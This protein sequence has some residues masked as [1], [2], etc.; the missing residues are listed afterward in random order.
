ML[1]KGIYVTRLL[2]QGRAQRHHN[3]SNGST[4]IFTRRP[5]REELVISF[6]LRQRSEREQIDACGDGL[7][8]FQGVL[9]L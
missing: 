6:G 8:M 3:I 4:L 2:I 5:M 1:Q 9:Y 7:A